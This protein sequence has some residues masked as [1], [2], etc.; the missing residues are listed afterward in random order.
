MHF[1][2]FN[3]INAKEGEEVLRLPQRRTY[4]SSRKG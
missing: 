4:S 1:V 2:K 3:K